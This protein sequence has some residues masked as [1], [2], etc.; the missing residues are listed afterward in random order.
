MCLSKT[1]LAA[2][3]SLTPL[4]KETS[5][6]ECI[7]P[8]LI[9]LHSERRE[10]EYGAADEIEL[11]FFIFLLCKFSVFCSSVLDENKQSDYLSQR[12]EKEL[13]R[14]QVRKGRQLVLLFRESHL[15]RFHSEHLQQTDGTSA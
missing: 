5:P 14:T 15:Y 9:P 13:V 2:P 6:R 1:K 12:V 4:P 7:P 8:L 11:S 3:E 10:T